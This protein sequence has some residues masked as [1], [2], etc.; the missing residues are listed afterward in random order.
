MGAKRCPPWKDLLEAI[1]TPPAQSPLQF[2]FSLF[3]TVTC[4]SLVWVDCI[5]SR[6][7]Y[8]ELRKLWVL[9]ESIGVVNLCLPNTPRTCIVCCVGVLVMA[10]SEITGSSATPPSISVDTPSPNHHLQ[11][12]CLQSWRFS[13]SD[14]PWR[15]SCCNWS[16]TPWPSYL[17]T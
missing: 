2:N 14:G 7:A 15:I 13:C 3:A 9:V 16:T 17:A 6:A 12:I 8:W 1:A 11:C 10:W 4:S 5:P